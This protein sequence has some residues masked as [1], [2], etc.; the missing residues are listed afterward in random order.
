M[1]LSAEHLTLYLRPRRGWQSLPKQIPRRCWP[2][3][4]ILD[5]AHADRVLVPIG[6]GGAAAYE[7]L[8]NSQLGSRPY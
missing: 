3:G 2:E 6:K 8:K 5:S 4:A 1:G 7:V